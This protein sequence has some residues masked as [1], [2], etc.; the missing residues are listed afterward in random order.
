LIQM[1]QQVFRVDHMFVGLITLG[2]MGVAADLLFE[3]TVRRLLPWY[4]ADKVEQRGVRTDRQPARTT[5][6]PAAE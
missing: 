5:A 4:G 2:T 6:K 3:L 1:S